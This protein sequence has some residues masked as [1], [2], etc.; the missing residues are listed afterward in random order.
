MEK[1][2]SAFDVSKGART[3]SEIEKLSKF[4][5]SSRQRFNCSHSPLFPKIEIDHVIPDTLHL[6]LR[7]ADVLINLL[8]LDLRRADGIDRM[9]CVK[10]DRAKLTNIAT[11]EKFL[12]ETCKIS[13][14]WYVSEDSKK[15]QWR[16]LT[17]PEKK[18]LF[19]NIDIP[20][21]FPALPNALIIQQVWMGFVDLIK[22]LS[23]TNLSAEELS[24][25]SERNT[26]AWVV[27]FTE[28]YQTKHVTPY[29]HC[30]AMHVPEFLRKYGDISAFSQQ[31]LEKLNDITT[32]HFFRSTN[33]K[34]T[35]ALK[36]L[37]QKRCRIETLEDK[38]CKR[39]KLIHKCSTCN[40]I[41]HNKRTCR[42]V[43]P[44]N[45]EEHSQ[46]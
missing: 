24:H 8:I 28:L 19:Q 18:V 30:F 45:S 34:E 46:S 2:W 35:E 6:F 7:I 39:K 36:Q 1:V 32:A 3:V 12:N 41:G 13:F 44:L 17:G 26:R 15:L 21:L 43:V 14:S 31:G 20:S 38:G 11:Y 37:I 42:T 33:H 22:V 4:P 5:K 40:E 23:Q 27:H 29:M 16:D 10:L 25:F 9:A